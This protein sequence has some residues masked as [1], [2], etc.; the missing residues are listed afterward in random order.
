MEFIEGVHERDIE[1]EGIDVAGVV[2]AGMRAVCR[3]IF[4]H[5]FVHA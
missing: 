5:A 2:Q 1:A 4:L 3:M